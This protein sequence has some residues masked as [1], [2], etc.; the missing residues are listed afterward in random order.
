MKKN[1]WAEFPPLCVIKTQVNV[2]SNTTETSARGK[3]GET[4]DYRSTSETRVLAAS[5]IAKGESAVWWEAIY[6]RQPL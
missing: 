2:D 6:C 5:G 4:R 1:D 3:A